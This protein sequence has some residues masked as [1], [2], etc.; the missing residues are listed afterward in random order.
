MKKGF[1]ILIGLILCFFILH[2]IVY[3]EDSDEVFNDEIY[4]IYHQQNY[5]VRIHYYLDEPRIVVSLCDEEE[6]LD[7]VTIWY[8]IDTNGEM[9]TDTFLQL[10][11]ARSLGSGSG[12]ERIAL[13][14]VKAGKLFESLD[15]ATNYS[16]IST[17]GQQHEYKVNFNLE[18]NSYK[19]F[20]LRVEESLYVYNELKD[21]PQHEEW[22]ETYTIPFDSEEMIFANGQTTLS[23]EFILENR[24]PREKRQLIN[25]QVMKFTLRNQER[26]YMDNK[27]YIS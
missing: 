3:A 24:K 21:P 9:L 19:D 11:F 8:W 27:W 26:L 4:D 18:G 17:L 12:G 7:R 25:K 14:S 13:F 15:I 20:S 16:D 6:V 2:N 10:T 1:F 5:T 23:G 22:K